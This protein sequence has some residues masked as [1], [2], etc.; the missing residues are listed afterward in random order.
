M[1]SPTFW[2]T[3]APEMADFSI[4][5]YSDAFRVPDPAVKWEAAVNEVVKEFRSGI[6]WL[7][8]QPMIS[9]VPRKT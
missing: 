2:S 7:L 4:F 1:R 9:R 8:A 6:R 5:H 3:N